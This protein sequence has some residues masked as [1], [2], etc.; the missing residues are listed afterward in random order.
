MV[1]A[2][3]LSNLGALGASISS[4]ASTYGDVASIT[5]ALQQNPLATVISEVA[6]VSSSLQSQ[7][8]AITNLPGAIGTSL[9]ASLTGLT[10][11]INSLTS[12][13]NL[14]SGLVLDT[15]SIPSGQLALTDLTSLGGVAMSSLGMTKEEVLAS[16]G[17]LTTGPALLATINDS[18]NINTPGDI[19][20]LVTAL[21]D[22]ATAGAEE[23]DLYII[24]D[25]IT[26]AVLVHQQE[27]EDMIQA[28][29]D[30]QADLKLR[31]DTLNILATILPDPSNEIAS[32]MFGLVATDELRTLNTTL[33]TAAST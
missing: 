18:L 23:A 25:Q 22:A 11:S 2:G 20:T 1:K 19:T 26:A 12:H 17:S 33:T 9:T 5:A 28:D 7:F 16:A 14:L 21:S 4:L 24:S 15:E 27:I 30:A 13:S 32:A 3:G 6:G 29:V 10:S 8:D 31:V